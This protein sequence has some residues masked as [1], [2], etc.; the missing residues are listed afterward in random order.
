MLCESFLAA[1]LM[2]KAYY[3]FKT[4]VIKV[5]STFQRFRLMEIAYKT[6][7]GCVGRKDRLTRQIERLK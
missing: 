3:I 6:S 2:S 5:S 1:I 7:A 4:P